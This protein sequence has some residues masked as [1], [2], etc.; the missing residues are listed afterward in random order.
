MFTPDIAYQEY[1]KTASQG[2]Y[3]SGPWQ[4]RARQ[5]AIGGFCALTGVFRASWRVVTLVEEVAKVAFYSM[6]SLV[7]LGGYDNSDRLKDHIKLLG[8]TFGALLYQ[9]VNA[10]IHLLAI[11]VGL[12]SP[13]AGSG[14]S[15]IASKPLAAIT[16]QEKAIWQSYKTPETYQKVLSVFHN[17]IDPILERSSRP[18]ELAGMTIVHEFSPAL[19]SA[20]LSPLVYMHT[21]RLFNANPQTLSEEQ[22]ALRPVILLNGNYSHQGTFLPLLHALACSHDKRPV[23]CF[24]LRPNS[25]ISSGSRVIEL[26]AHIKAQYGR[27]DDSTFKVDMIGHSM[28]SGCIQELRHRSDRPFTIGRAI[29]LGAPF[30]SCSKSHCE[31]PRDITGNQDRLVPYKSNLDSAHQK[32][33][34]TGHLGLL[35]HPESLS[36]IQAFLG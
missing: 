14:L 15:Y 26:V 24:N 3:D 1:F 23:Y 4:N 35:F 12:I 8:L 17:K 19:D 11:A 32:V 34:N 16:S 20:L 33:I 7:T 18:V 21:F 6:A 31:E 5:A 30:S 22:K 10:A 25:A 27:S 13:K 2:H 36:A 9:P 28:G 29:T